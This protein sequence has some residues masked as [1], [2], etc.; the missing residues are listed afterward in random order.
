MEL[1]SLMLL[2]TPL[3]SK[4]V[5]ESAVVLVVGAILA[6]GERTVSAVLSV[7]GLCD[8]SNYQNY[9]RF[10]SDGRLRSPLKKCEPIWGLK[11]ERQWSSLSIERTTPILLG[12]FSIVTALA[13]QQQKHQPFVLPKAAWYQKQQP[14][15]TDAL[16]LVRQQLWQI[17]TFQMSISESDTVKIPRSLFNTWSDLLC[18]AA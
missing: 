2:F 17:R 8:I 15:F 14:T 13:H 5:W 7:M 4:Q 9:Y 11:R 3:F 6:P 18:Y 1:M 10:G 12:L 16:A